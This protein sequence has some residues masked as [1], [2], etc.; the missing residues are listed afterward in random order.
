MS[1]SIR[2][3]TP[4][5][6][7]EITDIDLSEPLDDATVTEVK[8]AFEEHSVLL[9]PNQNISDE[10]HVAFSHHFGVTDAPRQHFAVYHHKP[11]VNAVINF[12]AEGNLFEDNDDRAKFRKGQ[13]MWHTDGSYRSIPSVS[14]I[15][16]ACM[17][18]PEGG[19]T[20]FASLRAAYNAL[21]DEQKTEY[22]NTAAIHHYGHSRRHMNITFLSKEEAEK[23]PPVR[24]PMVRSNPV[25]GKKALYVS[26]YAAYIEGRDKEEGCKH[27]EDLL[28]FA[29]QE[30]FVYDHQW[31]VGDMVMYD[32]RA[33]LHRATEYDIS[34][35]PRIL[36]RT[37]VADKQ[38]TLH[39][40]TVGTT[41]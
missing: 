19:H 10:E 21:S 4:V 37:N 17:V 38:P 23:Y 22:E 27:L 32:N 33:C 6:G 25:N 39:D 31:R 13:R 8:D 9:F 14:S 24:H 18:P 2:P 1:I 26:S 15:L 3:L 28:A 30:D 20:Q 5:F 35:Y 36:R 41:L 34:K 11:K 7:A 29:G 40:N 16:R 12:D